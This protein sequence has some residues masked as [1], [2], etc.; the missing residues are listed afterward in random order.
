MKSFEIEIPGRTP[1]CCHFFFGRS[2]FKAA[3][4][5]IAE[6]ELGYRVAVISDRKVA[7]LYADL[8]VEHLS[9]VDLKAT[10]ITFPPG[11]KNKSW[12][13]LGRL[14]EDMVEERFGRNSVVIALGG[15][16][17]GD[18]AGAA[19]ALYGRGVPWVQL[20]TTTVSMADSAIG[21]KTGVNVSG[22]KNLAGS[23]HQPAAVF[24][25][26]ETLA[27]LPKRHFRAGLAEVVKV[28]LIADEKLFE[29]I[30]VAYKDLMDPD[31]P[32]LEAVMA[33]CAAYKAGVVIRDE[34]D[35]GER[36]I[37]NAGHTIGHAVETLSR[38][39]I[40]HGE[41][42]AI[43]MAIECRLAQNVIGFP[44]KDLNRLLK[45]LEDLGLPIDLPKN[46][47]LEELEELLV[48]DKK[49]RGGKPFFALPRRIGAI[50]D[51]SGNWTVG[52]DSATVIKLLSESD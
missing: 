1:R 45:L 19:A 43:G 20:P 27:T 31:N 29:Q 40:L 3:A 23:F 12:K 21:G 26:L 48:V 7:D 36:M 22:V 52:V 28:A 13:T 14:L 17:T 24:G 30:E 42:V 34:R 11:E 35:S 37:L 10:L 41:A 33:G 49:S 38:G 46:I 50:G 8:L 51:G 18:L 32:L 25:D 39:R 47:E 16:V 44:R 9:S 15:G 5:W 6:K 2:M 4:D